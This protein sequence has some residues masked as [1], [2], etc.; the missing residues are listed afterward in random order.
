[1]KKKGQFDLL[2]T[3]SIAAFI[4]LFVVI[5]ILA[6][7]I[8]VTQTMID[9]YL[10]NKEYDIPM[11]LFSVDIND[12]SSAI[13]LNRAFYNSK[14]GG[15]Y[16]DWI[17]QTETTINRWFI[18][19]T[20]QKTYQYYNFELGT[21]ALEGEVGCACI[22][23]GI[24]ISS[25]TPSQYECAGSACSPTGEDCPPTDNKFTCT[26]YCLKK[27]V[28]KTSITQRSNLGLYPTPIIY[29]GTDR[30]V[31]LKFD[32]VIAENKAG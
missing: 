23:S 12:E 6:F 17:Q 31:P 8:H 26:E 4:V 1:M 27:S 30:V 28:C 19:N 14:F 25:P 9:Y 18:R 15:N 32:T 2:A 16:N 11:A 20:N 29:N 21:V 24:P 13:A 5:F 7:K 3:F 22:A 10:W